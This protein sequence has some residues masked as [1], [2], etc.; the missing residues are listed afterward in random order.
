M[1]TTNGAPR[2]PAARQRGTAG[3]KRSA[4]AVV[5]GAFAL[6]VGLRPRRLSAGR[7]SPQHTGYAE[8]AVRLFRH[9]AR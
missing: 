7:D 8:A 4:A 2:I 9:T 6:V 3:G 1:K 5:T